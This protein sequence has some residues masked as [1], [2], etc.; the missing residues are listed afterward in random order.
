MIHGLKQL[1][2]LRKRGKRPVYLEL[3]IDCEHL[4]IIY[5]ADFAYM[6]LATS[7]NVNTD[8][9]RP[10]VGLDV[11]VYSPKATSRYTDAI[12]RLKQHAE[13][14]TVFCGDYGL[15]L[16]FE[17]SKKWGVCELGETYW[18]DRW[19][20]ARKTLCRTKAEV[21]ERMRVEAEALAHCPWIPERMLANGK[22]AA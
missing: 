17:W 1:I 10:F 18:A 13:R 12:D 20:N 8:D 22:A 11:F 2:E 5:S 6:V 19:D 3:D 4:P 16:G 15:D 14:L 7:G 21:D 9:F